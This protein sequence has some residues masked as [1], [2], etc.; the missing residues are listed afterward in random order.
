MGSFSGYNFSLIGR[1]CANTG[2]S[3]YSDAWQKSV[4]ENSAWIPATA[5]SAK[6]FLAVLAYSMVLAETFQ[7]IVNT[8]G[9]NAG[10]AQT[11]ITLT[12]TV[13]F[14]LCSMKNL[15]SLAP[16]SIMGIIGM[17]FTVG[18][19]VVRY[20]DGSYA[21]PAGKFLE[22]IGKLPVFGKK[23]ASAALTPNVFILV[24]MLSTAFM[25]SSLCFDNLFGSFYIHF[26]LIVKMNRHISMHQ[27][28]TMNLKTTQLKDLIHL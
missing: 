17:L 10:R 24:C 1:I 3:S 16:F 6:T 4:G 26:F 14:P 5:C 25:V 2:A 20:V 9:I 18:V 21:L 23:G 12:A 15:A 13:L 27:N 11:L 19:M 22:S 8:M 28:F 7:G